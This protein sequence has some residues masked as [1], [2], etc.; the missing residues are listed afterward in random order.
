MSRG[1]RGLARVDRLYRGGQETKIL[2]RDSPDKS[3]LPCKSRPNSA[4]G[5]SGHVDSH[6]NDHIG[7]QANL[8]LGLAQLFDRLG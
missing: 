6:R 3:C 8:N 4:L 5:F 1:S 2:W 7:V